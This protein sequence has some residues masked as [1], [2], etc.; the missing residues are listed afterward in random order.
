MSSEN[1][2]PDFVDLCCPQIINIGPITKQPTNSNSNSNSNKSN[3]CHCITCNQKYINEHDFKHNKNNFDIIPTS[4]GC[5]NIE[6]LYEQE[7]IYA[8]A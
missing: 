4:H 7:L 5:I 2:C 6:R 1:Y 8:R 3:I